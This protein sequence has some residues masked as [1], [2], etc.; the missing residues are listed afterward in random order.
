MDKFAVLRKEIENRIAEAKAN[1][2]EYRD[3]RIDSTDFGDK[4]YLHDVEYRF[5]WH[6]TKLTELLKFAD[7]LSD[8][9]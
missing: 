4:G 9:S 2:K 5:G 7:K 1:E 8:E 3:A 6:A